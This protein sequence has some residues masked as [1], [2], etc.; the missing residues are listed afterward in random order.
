[1]S[2]S[3]TKLEEGNAGDH[4]YVIAEIDITS[5]DSAGTEP[6]D[7]RARFGLRSVYGADVLDQEDHTKTFH[8]DAD[9]DDIIVKEVND[10]GDGTGGVA[11][12]ANNTDVGTV[13]M[14]FDGNWAP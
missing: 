6:F 7:P 13:I 12:V 8:F 11:D 14:R 4:V 9:N 2:N 5:L 3:T 10:T 1:M